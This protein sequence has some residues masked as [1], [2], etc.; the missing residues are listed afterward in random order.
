MNL[1]RRQS[2]QTTDACWEQDGS[3]QGSNVLVYPEGVLYSGV[4]LEDVNE[5]FTSHLENGTPV[6]RLLASAAVW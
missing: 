2:T 5:I 1:L 3:E 4:T 6:T